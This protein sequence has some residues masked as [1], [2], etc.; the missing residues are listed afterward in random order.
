LAFK[1]VGKSYD[2]ISFAAIIILPIIKSKEELSQIISTQQNDRRFPQ[3]KRQPNLIP[4]SMEIFSCWS[5]PYWAE[6]RDFR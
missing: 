6:N 2:Y 4:V 3:T 5:I 1:V